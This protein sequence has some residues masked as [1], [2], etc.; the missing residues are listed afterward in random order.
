MSLGMR[1]LGA[2][3]LVAALAAGNVARETCWTQADGFLCGP[4]A[5][6]PLDT[7]I[8]PIQVTG[9]TRVEIAAPEWRPLTI[10]VQ[11]AGPGAVRLSERPDE[12]G[13]VVDAGRAASLVV[14]LAPTPAAPL[15]LWAE[16]TAGSP[17]PVV[18]RVTALA[19]V[20]APGRVS[21]ALAAGAAAGAALAWALL[22]GR[23]GTV[24]GKAPAG[25]EPTDRRSTW[26]API[27]LLAVVHGAW[28][29]LKPPLQS[30]DEPQHH[31]RATSAPRTPYVAGTRTV[32][33]AAAHRNPLTWTPNR[34][35]AIIFQPAE[36]LSDADIRALR[37]TAWPPPGAY[38]S[39]ET[40][41]SPIASYPPVYYWLVFA[42][43]ELATWLFGLGPYASLL[44][45]RVVSALIAG[46][47]WLAVYR[48][49]RRTPDLRPWSLP[50]FVVLIANPATASITSS[51]NPDAVAIPA[52]ALLL[53][54]TWRRLTAGDGDTTLVAGAVL[55][56]AVKP[57]GLLATAS[58]GAAVLWWMARQ[59]SG[60]AA[61]V[62]VLRL[63]ILV[64]VAAQVIFY[65]WSP[66]RLIA[67]AAH[68]SDS[69]RTFLGTLVE[70]APSWWVEY[71]GRLGWLEYAAP[72][73]W[74]WI[75]FGA[76]LVLLALAWRRP[77]P[78]GSAESAG[79]GAFLAVAGL[80]YAGLLL[81]GEY[82]HLDTAPLFVQ[83]RYLLPASVCLVP[84]VRQRS[85]ALAWAL[86]VLLAALNVALAQ[87][88]MDRYFTS[89]WA[90]WFA[91]LS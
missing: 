73:A 51:V 61:G 42:G 89:G 22:F 35:H 57:S 33:V 87:A 16:T 27:A 41:F 28:V 30:P 38:P 12:A 25:A 74:Y 63:L 67:D 52:T 17:A 6:R 26:L 60:R 66:P 23:G 46:G 43:G 8:A 37:S 81:A 5:S 78:D 39:A 21:L 36:R 56:L 69:L 85:P 18:V 31:A 79:I 20:F 45:Y 58:A 83:G 44:A 71:W 82:V 88:T 70:R 15:R 3:V 55:A 4:F 80:G 62:A 2:A 84:L 11:V 32:T 54:A 68:A 75:L 53:L 65:A 48:E 76:C 72:P 77:A 90:G 29:L 1:L 91:S 24:A 34:L 40:L 59:P 50:A 9:L 47:I 86:P 13:V 10:A 19:P 7:V 14:R 49:L 64:S